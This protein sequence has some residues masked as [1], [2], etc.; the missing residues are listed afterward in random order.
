[1]GVS[2]MSTVCVGL[3]LIVEYVKFRI[4][5]VQHH[6]DTFNADHHSFQYEKMLNETQ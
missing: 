6:N 5:L 2:Y 3:V 4:T 1:M